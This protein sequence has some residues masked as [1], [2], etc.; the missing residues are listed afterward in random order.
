MPNGIQYSIGA[1]PVGCLRK[2]NMLISNNTADTGTS[3]YTGINP[4]SGGYTIYLNKASGGPSIYCPANDTKLIDITNKNIAGTVGSPAG[5]TTVAQCLNYFVTQTDKLCVNFNYEGIITNGLVLNL[6]AGFDPSYP[7][8][9]STWYD[10]SGNS[11]NGTLTNGPTFNSADSGSIVFDGVDDRVT[12]ATNSITSNSLTFIIWIKRFSFGTQGTGLVFNRGNGGSTT[13]MNINWPTP[14]NGLG[15]HWNDDTNTY[16]YNPGLSIPLNTWCF[17]CVSVSPTQAIFQV[18]NS[19]VVRSY[20]NVT[21]N[22]T[23]GTNLM[24]GTDYTINRF[25]NANIAYASMYNRA[26][27]QSEITQNYNAQKGRFGL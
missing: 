20:T 14:S 13:G 19:T 16:S 8:T 27:S 4:P 10:L 17:C 2:G 25:V 24:I 5:Y 3:F 11:S 22:T 7:T 9:G 6:D 18:N 15:Y 21:A 23:V 1:T 26:L 12:C